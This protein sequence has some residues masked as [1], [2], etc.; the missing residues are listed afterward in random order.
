MRDPSRLLFGVR[1][2]SPFILQSSRSLRPR[3]LPS[4]SAAGGFTFAF[5][6]AVLSLLFS[7]PRA[8]HAQRI[9]VRGGARIEAHA[10]RASG[11]LV[12]SGT[13][14]A[15]TARAIGPE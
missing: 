12:L 3:S 6:F 1:M 2:R 9:H 14:V 7:D 15:A 10:A 11:K 8:A 13:R 5:A 4:R